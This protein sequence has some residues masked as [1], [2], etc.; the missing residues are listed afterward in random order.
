M[1]KKAS[2][3]ALLTCLLWA[4]AGQA[5]NTPP[6]PP[7]KHP[8]N[9][10][11]CN[12]QASA[13]YVPGVDVKGRPVA[14]ADLPGGPDVIVSTEVYPEIRSRNPQVPRTGLSVQIEGLGAPPRCVPA[15]A[16]VPAKPR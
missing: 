5:A 14:P 7:V 6:P 10:P 15:P 8:P 9:P 12:P 2:R 3:A 11:A 1:L 13:D 16:P 4:G